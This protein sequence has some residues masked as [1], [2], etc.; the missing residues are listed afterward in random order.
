MRVTNGQTG[1]A[2]SQSVAVLTPLCMCLGEGQT[3]AEM[4]W[5]KE[6]SHLEKGT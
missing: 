4:Q 6:P 1:V 2:L 5:G 3:A